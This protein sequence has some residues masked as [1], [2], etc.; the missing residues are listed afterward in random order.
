MTLYFFTVHPYIIVVYYRKGVREMR[1][2]MKL[3]DELKEKNE[4]KEEAKE[5][6]NEADM[7]L[8][9]DDLD[10]VSGGVSLQNI[11]NTLSM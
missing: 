6:I 3:T 10:N 11:K 4:A 2:V 8:S 9:D 5:L 1:F 7:E